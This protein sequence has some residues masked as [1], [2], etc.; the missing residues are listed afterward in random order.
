M[1]PNEAVP[2]GAILAPHHYT[3]G[4]LLA[5]LAVAVVWDN[6]SDREPLLAA[7]GLGA[8][9]FGFLS[10]WPYYPAAGAIMALAGPSLAVV[11]VAAGTLGLSVGDSWDNYPRRE[12]VAVVVF[13]AVALDDAVEHAFGWP[14]PLDTVW[15]RYLI[16]HVPLVALG[17]VGLVAGAVVVQAVRNQPKE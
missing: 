5:L 17:L 7:V 13:S 16:E 2:D 11:A 14:T 9:L 10:V 3:Y 12:R 8:G 6:R 1:F 4:A 15:E